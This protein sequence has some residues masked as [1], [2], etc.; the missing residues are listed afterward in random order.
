LDDIEYEQWHC[1][2]DEEKYGAG[3]GGRTGAERPA[4]PDQREWVATAGSRPLQMVPTEYYDVTDRRTSRRSG[5]GQCGRRAWRDRCSALDASAQAAGEGGVRA[6]H[7]D[8]GQ[9]PG[10]RLRTAG[11]CSRTTATAARLADF[12]GDLN[13]MNQAAAASSALLVRGF[14]WNPATYDQQ[15]SWHRAIA[16]RASATGTIA[17]SNSP[18]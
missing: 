2:E 14:G 1:A 10:Q 6:R 8:L 3:G 9:L 18:T 17:A 7:P 5:A 13:P 12:V 11:S 15:A 16:E 4:E